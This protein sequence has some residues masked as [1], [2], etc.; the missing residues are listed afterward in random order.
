MSK[1]KENGVEAEKVKTRC[2]HCLG[3]LDDFQEY[4]QHL[5]DKHPED[6]IRTDWARSVLETGTI[7]LDVVFEEVAIEAANRCLGTARPIDVVTSKLLKERH[8]KLSKEDVVRVVNR[9]TIIAE[10]CI[11]ESKII[12]PLEVEQMS[13]EWAV[14][15]LYAASEN[16]G[17]LSDEFRRALSISHHALVE[18][19]VR[20]SDILATPQTPEFT[21]Q[22]LSYEV[23][24]IHKLMA[25][26][27]RF[28]SGNYQGDL[29]T[30]C[31]VAQSLIKLLSEQFGY[32]PGEL[33]E[34][35]LECL[36]KRMKEIEKKRVE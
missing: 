12:K 10:A 3:E 28:G 2:P 5:I 26:Q 31:A 1:I 13:R 29:K 20:V 6:K 36:K 8:M 34:L 17:F 18:K 27:E 25:Y 9:A 24:D 21:A 35:G 7:D 14:E 32:D 30:A 23:G 33:E 11:A 19:P 15:V 16:V 4:A 22:M